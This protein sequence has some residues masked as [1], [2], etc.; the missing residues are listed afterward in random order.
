MTL[1]LIEEITEK[2]EF[3]SDE[4]FQKILNHDTV[5]MKEWGNRISQA[6]WGLDIV[7][8]NLV[9]VFEEL[10]NFEKAYGFF[11]VTAEGPNYIGLSPRLVK[12]NYY[13]S[14]NVELIFMHELCHAYIYSIH[15]FEASNDFSAVFEKEIIR[16]GA[17]SQL[18]ISLGKFVAIKYKPRKKPE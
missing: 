9:P 14:R 8:D 16:I 1:N 3:I 17:V 4:E 13:S 15:G 7:D 5:A 11:L 18:D 12:H 10:N 6:K 2:A